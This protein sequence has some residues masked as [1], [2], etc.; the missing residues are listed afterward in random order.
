MADDAGPGT[1]G[2]GGGF[3]SDG[4]AGISW[5]TLT[6]F[7][8]EAIREALPSA[9]KF[10]GAGSTFAAAIHWTDL[11]ESLIAWV[12]AIVGYNWVAAIQAVG[13]A[14]AAVLIGVGEWG[15][16]LLAAVVGDKSMGMLALNNA[17]RSAETALASAGL[18]AWLIAVAEALVMLHLFRLAFEQMG[19]IGGGA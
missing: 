4:F 13:Q 15:A 17:M 1:G 16:A 3:T 12:V 2:G 14:N 19:F 11:G 7:D 8:P 5:G 9:S 18:G 10:V 6:S